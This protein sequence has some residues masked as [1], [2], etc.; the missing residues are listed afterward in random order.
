MATPFVSGL[1]AIA[2]REAPQ[3]S[4]YQIKGVILGAVDVKSNLANSRLTGSK[5]SVFFHSND[6]FQPL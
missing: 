6:L 2:I 4:A 5:K 1:A 3:L